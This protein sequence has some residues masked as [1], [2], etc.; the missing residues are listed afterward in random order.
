MGE[1]PTDRNEVLFGN[2]GSRVQKFSTAT[3]WND[4]RQIGLEVPSPTATHGSLRGGSGFREIGSL[5]RWGEFP[6][7]GR[8]AGAGFAEK[9]LVGCFFRTSQCASKDRKDQECGAR[10]LVVLGFESN[11]LGCVGEL[12]IILEHVSFNL[13]NL[14]DI[15]SEERYL[16]EVKLSWN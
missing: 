6:T 13:I 15:Q 1:L 3:E 4:F 2:F 7:D 14:G 9:T 12:N 11:R 10:R 5:S 16:S 8:R